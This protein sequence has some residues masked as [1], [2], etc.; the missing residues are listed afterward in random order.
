M[1]TEHI[2]NHDS[3]E[4]K[5]MDSRLTCHEIESCTTEDLP[6]LLKLRLPPVDVMCKLGKGVPS[7][8]SSLSSGHQSGSYGPPILF[9][10]CANN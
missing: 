4:D 9:R 10:G 8:V 2:C 6:C 1:L 5:L 3:R 7:L